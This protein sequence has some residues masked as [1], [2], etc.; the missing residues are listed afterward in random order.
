MDVNSD[1][2][3][4]RQSLAAE[5]RDVLAG[6]P[7]SAAADARAA[8]RAYSLRR[9]FPANRLSG[10][11]PAGHVPTSLPRVPDAGQYADPGADPRN[12]APVS[13]PSRSS[14]EP[15]SQALGPKRVLGFVLSWPLA[16]TVMVVLLLSAGLIGYGLARRGSAPQ[17]IPAPTIDATRDR[18]FPSFGFDPVAASPMTTPVP[19]TAAP[20]PSG[21]LSPAGPAPSP[22]QSASAT[23]L[24]SAAPGTRD[25]YTVIQA[26]SYTAQAGTRAERCSDVGGGQDL[27]YLAPGDWL[28]YDMVDFGSVGATQFFIRFASDLPAG[29]SGSV[30]VRLDALDNSP[31]LSVPVATTG[32]WQ[33]WITITASL[34]RV[35]GVHAVYLTFTSSSG[36]EIGNINWFTFKA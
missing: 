14:S 24:A 27:G 18:Q 2:P 1:D 4:T 35:T 32:G 28:A 16:A 33:S 25:A 22:T 21:R 12:V 7:A 15:L 34:T 3:T 13:S 31:V 5:P 11:E 29:M 8:E 26:E 30:E 17:A 19:S 20:L 9:L 10:T 23:Q 6:K 36:W